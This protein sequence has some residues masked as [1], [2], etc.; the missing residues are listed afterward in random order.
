MKT[1][2]RIRPL[3][4][5]LVAL[6]GLSVNGCARR[7][8]PVVEKPSNPLRTYAQTTKAEYSYRLHK[9][10]PGKG[11]TTHVLRLISGKWLTENEVQETE[12]WHWLHV[13]VPDSL[14]SST[15][16]LMIGGGKREDSEPK[17][18]P[19]SLRQIALQT[20]SVVAHLHNVPNQPLNFINDPYGRRSEDEIIAYGWRKFLEAGG[21]EDQVQWLARLPMTR[22]AVRAMDAIT[23][24]TTQML[25]RPVTRFVTAGGSK[26]GWTT[27]ATAIAD[28]RVVAIAPL[29]ID[30]LNLEPSFRHHWQAYGQWSPA[31]DDYVRE[32]IMEWMG[33][34]EFNRLLKY[35]DPYSYRKQ[36]T[37]PKMVINASGDE[38]FLPDSW[39]FYWQDLVGEKHLRYV[40]NTGHSLS[41]TD[42]EETV[43]AF[44]ESVVKQTPR[45]DFNWRVDQGALVIE[46]SPNQPPQSIK[47]WQATNDKAR[48]FRLPVL[49]KAYSSTDVPLSSDGKY[50]IA[51]TP[52][53]KGWTAFFVELT[54]PGPGRTPFKLTTGVTVTP[55]QLPYPAFK[56]TTPKGTPFEPQKAGGF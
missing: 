1:I 6:Y 55:E 23:D 5:L 16:L 27:W 26:R 52:P 51:V 20:H 17:D 21:G 30:L 4:V 35:A 2:V 10:I 36:L 47:L 13:V 37:L 12:W 31:V 11:Y 8:E 29:V 54:Y 33:T 9:T 32:G 56:P 24:Y 7:L 28:E 39:Q 15:A 18:A 48:D 25:G 53:E 3:L 42:A 14:S 46:T 45:P 38:F 34:V 19:S 50:R 40:P 49:G 44:F 41:K 43:A 22:A